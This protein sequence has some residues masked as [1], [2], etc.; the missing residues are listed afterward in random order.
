MSPFC[1]RHWL[2]SPREVGFLQTPS[3][4]AGTFGPC[5]HLLFAGWSI[6]SS[7]IMILKAWPVTVARFQAGAW[8]HFL[9]LPWLR[10]PLRAG[11]CPALPFCSAGAVYPEICCSVPSKALTTLLL[12]WT[13]LNSSLPGLLGPSYP[14]CFKHTEALPDIYRLT[15]TPPSGFYSNVIFSENLSPAILS[16]IAIHIPYTHFILVFAHIAISL[17][18]YFTH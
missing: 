1:A 13:H 9:P 8:C 17:N 18:M 12:L 2:P 14:D 4:L 10:C 3:V 11:H 5:W 15:S 16:K 7:R 6:G